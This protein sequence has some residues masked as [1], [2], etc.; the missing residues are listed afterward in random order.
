MKMHNS[1]LP[2]SPTANFVQAARPGRNTARILAGPLR[3]LHEPP[4]EKRVLR[5]TRAFHE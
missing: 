2:P 4:C 5:D 1:R 3:L